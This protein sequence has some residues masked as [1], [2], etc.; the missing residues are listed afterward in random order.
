MPDIITQTLPCPAPLLGFIIG[1]RGHA[2]KSMQDASGATFH[3][4]DRERVSDYNVEYVYIRLRGLPHQVD[5][6][7]R[8]V[9]LRLYNLSQADQ[10]A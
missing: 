3:I 4:N 9:M 6:A 7:K 2:I 1:K 10:R 8:L 5:R